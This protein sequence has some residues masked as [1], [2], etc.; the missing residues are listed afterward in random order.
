MIL[1]TG[2]VVARAETFEEI[3]TL[4]LEHV[5]RSRSEPGC[6][7]HD[8]HIDC[9]NPLRLVFVERWRDAEALRAHFAVSASAA[10]VRAVRALAAEK[11]AMTLYEAAETAL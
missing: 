11:T 2:A 7:S 9:E 1:V 3:R 8:V 10:F 5:R 6:I 4:S